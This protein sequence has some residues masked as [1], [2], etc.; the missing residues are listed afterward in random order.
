MEP[1]EYEK[2]VSKYPI[3]TLENTTYARTRI[4]LRPKVLT[5][6]GMDFEKRFWLGPK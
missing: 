6:D 3:E 5:S 1:L 4:V 2:A